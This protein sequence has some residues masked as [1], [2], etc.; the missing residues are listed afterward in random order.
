MHR[1]S[2]GRILKFSIQTLNFAMLRGCQ[3]NDVNGLKK[4]TGSEADILT[5][6]MTKERLEKIFLSLLIQRLSGQ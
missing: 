5:P 2:R 3:V 4:N 1:V 6:I